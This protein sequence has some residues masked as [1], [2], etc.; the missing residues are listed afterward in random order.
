MDKIKTSSTDTQTAMSLNRVILPCP[1]YGSFLFAQAIS[2]SP[3]ISQALRKTG[4]NA[5]MCCK[6]LAYARTT[7]KS[8]TGDLPKI[9]STACVYTQAGKHPSFPSRK[10]ECFC[11]QGAYPPV[12][13]NR[14]NEIPRA[15]AWF[16][17]FA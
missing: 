16:P 15:A 13:L 12:P 4:G 5:F 14:K 10:S 7:R 6:T 8:P 11:L 1:G 2:H 9:A 17:I 3:N